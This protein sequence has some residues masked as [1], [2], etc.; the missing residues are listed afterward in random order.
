M[1]LR[2]MTM[3]RVTGLCLVIRLIYLKKTNIMIPIL[4]VSLIFCLLVVFDA[5]E[6]AFNRHHETARL[7]H[8]F[9]N[10]F[11]T[12]FLVF[13]VFCVSFFFQHQFN[14]F[15]DSVASFLILLFAYIF[16]R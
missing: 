4:I 6:D 13:V 16:F 11:I 15:V 7:G 5:L 14:S 3:E 12:L 9:G 2:L 10:V 8:S 1:I